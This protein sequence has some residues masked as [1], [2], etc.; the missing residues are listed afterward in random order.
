MNR[1]FN[2]VRARLRDFETELALREEQPTNQWGDLVASIQNAVFS[3]KLL[4]VGASPNLIL[5]TDGVVAPP[6]ATLYD[7]MIMSLNREDITTTVLQTGFG[8]NAASPYGYVPDTEMLKFLCA[9]TNGS[10]FDSQTL[11]R[12]V[13]HKSATYGSGTLGIHSCSN[14]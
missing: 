14:C 2:V 9:S 13:L 6:D 10:F 8:Y 11:T 3:L 1:L 4:P 5:I 12:A 7:N